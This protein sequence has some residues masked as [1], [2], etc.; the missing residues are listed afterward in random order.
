MESLSQP[1][2]ATRTRTRTRT[3]T[4]LFLIQSYSDIGR[5]FQLKRPFGFNESEGADG[6]YLVQFASLFVDENVVVGSAPASAGQTSI[7][8]YGSL[9]GL[10]E[11]LAS[12]CNGKLLESEARH[13]AGY[14]FY[15]YKFETPLDMNLPCTGPKDRRPTV[16]K[17]RLWSVSATSNDVLFLASESKLQ[18]SLYSFLPR[19]SILVGRGKRGVGCGFWDVLGLYGTLNMH[20][21]TSR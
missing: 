14:T 12:K 13:T 5:G 16:A 10:G 4:L 15:K 18:V 2:T 7:T 20:L 3:R 17:S 1:S 21:R 9:E 6:D 19:L 8:D 11:K